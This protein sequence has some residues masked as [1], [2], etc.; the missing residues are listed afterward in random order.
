MIWC[1]RLT[2]VIAGAGANGR[3]SGGFDITAFAKFQAGN[4]MCDVIMIHIF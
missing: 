3:F 4:C 1:V 2:T